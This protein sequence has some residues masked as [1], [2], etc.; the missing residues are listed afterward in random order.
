MGL[1]ISLRIFLV[2]PERL[3]DRVSVRSSLKGFCSAIRTS[4]TRMAKKII[5]DTIVFTP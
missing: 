4:R 5:V 3:K 1:S 2:C